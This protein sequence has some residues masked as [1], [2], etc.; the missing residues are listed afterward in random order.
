MAKFITE[1]ELNHEIVKLFKEAEKTL[2]IVS[3]YIKLHPHIQSALKS[4]KSNH[5]LKVSLLF[6]KN[7]ENPALSLRQEDLQFFMDFPNIEIR[8]NEHLHAKYYANELDGILTSMNLHSFSQDHN[9]EFGIL[10]K[11]NFVK[12]IFSSVAGG[13]NLDGDAWRFFH[14]ILDQSSLI[15]QKEAQFETSMM[16]LK[17][18]YIRSV[19]LKDETKLFFQDTPAD[20]ATHR[21]NK[22]TGYCIR[23]GK[24]IPFNPERPLCEEAYNSW[25]KFSNPDYPEKFCHFSGEPSNGETTFGRPILRKNWT[26]AKQTHGLK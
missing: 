6:G 10:M 11:A 17:K 22:P 7:R 20:S 14:E 15:F 8:Y 26:S 19:I 5:E 18:A 1:T 21:K 4:K 3:P 25:A 16:G 2:L 9:I 12:D 23:T 13:P 24:T